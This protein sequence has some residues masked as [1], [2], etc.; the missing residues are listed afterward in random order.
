[1]KK[2]SDQHRHSLVTKK[3]GNKNGDVFSWLTTNEAVREKDALRGF[4]VLL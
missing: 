2:K 1:M 4:F 3:E